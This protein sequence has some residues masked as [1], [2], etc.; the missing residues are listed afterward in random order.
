M[1]LNMCSSTNSWLALYTKS[2]NLWLKSEVN[3]MIE[4]KGFYKEYEDM[5]EEYLE[6]TIGNK[7][8]SWYKYFTIWK[9]LKQKNCSF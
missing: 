6:A 7:K 8:I 4:I 9:K 5:F 1:L 2:T 3:V